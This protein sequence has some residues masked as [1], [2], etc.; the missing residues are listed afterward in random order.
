MINH[1]EENDED[2]EVGE[3]SQ[4][5]SKQEFHEDELVA[6]EYYNSFNQK[7][8]KRT[9]EI[10]ESE[11]EIRQEIGEDIE[12]DGQKR[13]ANYQILKNKGLTPHRSKLVR[14]PRVKRRV[15]YE[16]AVKKLGTFKRVVKDKAKIGKY[17]GE[18]T[19]IKTHLIRSVKF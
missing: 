9:T 8:H 1:D 18:S 10:L 13:P 17:G 15:K 19:G 12:E 6:L 16:K 2:E 7:K 14:N 3:E 11:T 5:I 4:I